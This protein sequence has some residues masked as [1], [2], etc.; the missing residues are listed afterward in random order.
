MPVLKDTVRSLL[1]V[2]KEQL[3]MAAR[4]LFFSSRI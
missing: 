3:W 2:S 4:G 1:S